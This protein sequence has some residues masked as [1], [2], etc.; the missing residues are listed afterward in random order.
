MYQIMYHVLLAAVVC[1]KLS[2][3]NFQ[4]MEDVCKGYQGGAK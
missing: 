4:D 3:V 1:S 2:L